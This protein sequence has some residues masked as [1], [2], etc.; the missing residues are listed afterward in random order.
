MFAIT[1]FLTIQWIHFQMYRTSEILRC[2]AHDDYNVRMLPQR[3]GPKTDPD[4]SSLN[5]EAIK[6]AVAARTPQIFLAAAA[7]AM[8][9][10]PRRGMLTTTRAV[11]VAHPGT[12]CT[13][14]RPVLTGCV[15]VTRKRGAV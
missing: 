14:A 1:I 4:P 6:Q 12:A 10:V 13:V 11:M 5:G 9:R 7:G 15:R 3:G 8:R 2:M